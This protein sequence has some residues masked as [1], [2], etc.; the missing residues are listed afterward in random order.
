MGKA[1]RRPNVLVPLTL[2]GATEAK[3]GVVAQQARAFDACVTLLH[4]LDGAEPAHEGLRPAAET[5]AQSFLADVRDELRRD[6]VCA[7]AAVRYG[8]VPAAVSQV[9]HERRASMIIVGASEPGRLQR[10]LIGGAGLAGAISRAAD[11]PVL[12][13]RRQLPADIADA[14]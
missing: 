3:L 12:V 1:N 10:R 8:A 4:V 11:S 6:G 13:V 14:A 5:E 7:E 2:G 9:A